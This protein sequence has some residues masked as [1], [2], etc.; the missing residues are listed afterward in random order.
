MLSSLK[1]ERSVPAGRLRGSATPIQRLLAGHLVG[2]HD[3]R[4]QLA[5][6]HL[7]DGVL[8]RRPQSEA[9]QETAYAVDRVFPVLEPRVV[10]EADVGPARHQVGVAPVLVCIFRQ[11]KPQVASNPFEIMRQRT[12]RQLETQ[13]LN[14]MRLCKPGGATVQDYYARPPDRKALVSNPFATQTEIPN[15]TIEL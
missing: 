13:L 11:A 14:R 5:L 2:G 7:V 1:V 8:D 12:C 4:E 6:V 15:A 10:I 3:L 9:L